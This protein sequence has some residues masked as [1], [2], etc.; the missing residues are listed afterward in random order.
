MWDGLVTT[1]RGR[2]CLPTSQTAHNRHDLLIHAN[3][4]VNISTNVHLM[5]FIIDLVY[6]LVYVHKYKLTTSL[7]H[8]VLLISSYYLYQLLIQGL[9]MQIMYT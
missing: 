1:P 2:P 5:P 8:P 9:Y 7:P 4:Y 3:Y 6:G